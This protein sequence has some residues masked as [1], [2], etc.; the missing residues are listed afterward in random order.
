M[1]EILDRGVHLNVNPITT[2]ID[3]KSKVFALNNAPF[4]SPTHHCSIDGALWYLTLTAPFFPMSY[5]NVAY[6]IMIVE[7]NTTSQPNESS[8]T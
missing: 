4:S 3:T 7:K 1:L 6:P 5:N 2:P 8:A